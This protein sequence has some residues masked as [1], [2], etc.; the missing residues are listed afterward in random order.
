MY[1]NF[2]KENSPPPGGLLHPTEDNHVYFQCPIGELKSSPGIYW[3]KQTN[4]VVYRAE[5][6]KSGEINFFEITKEITQ[7]QNIWLRCTNSFSYS[8]R[9]IAKAE[10]GKFAE[11][12]IALARCDPLK[13]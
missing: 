2:F 13:P 4:T 3:Q 11:D 6:L 1:S 7:N 10:A 5:E 9:P 8:E 12:V